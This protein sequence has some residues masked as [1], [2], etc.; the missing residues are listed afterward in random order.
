MA[1]RKRTRGSFRLVPDRRNGIYLCRFYLEG[2]EKSLS[3]RTRDRAEAKIVAARLYAEAVSGRRQ[4]D[5]PKRGDLAPIVA[6]W[7]AAIEGS[8]KSADWDGCERA[9]RVHLLPYFSRIEQLTPASLEDYYRARLRQVTASTVKKERGALVRF[10]KWATMDGRNL[11]AP[12]DVATL[13]KKAKGTKK[14]DGRDKTPISRT[15]VLAILD[16]LPEHSRMGHPVKAFVTLGAELGIRREMLDKLSVPEHYEPG[17]DYLRLTDD[18][19]K[20]GNGRPL[21]LTPR[22]REALEAVAP[23][24][25]RIFSGFGY[26]KTF[27]AAARPVVGNN[28]ANYLTL[29]D[30]RHRCLTDVAER[31]GLAAAAYV[32]GHSSTEMAGRVYVSPQA[33]SAEAALR[34]RAR[35]ESGT[36]CGTAPIRPESETTIAQDS[37]QTRRDSNPRPLPPEGSALSS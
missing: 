36:D 3:T 7:L 35:E 12:I 26:L 22:A 10:V 13:P 6:K 14:L 15:E 34:A 2:I 5:P 24:R 29:R 27:R 37:W 25:G 16:S 31:E 20:E 23:R 30:L 9:W 33:D 8:V 18:I 28:R 21:W 4:V 1:R 19:D 11:I 17:A 32:G